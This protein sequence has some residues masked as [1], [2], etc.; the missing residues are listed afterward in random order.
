MEGI[1]CLLNALEAET[2]SPFASGKLRDHNQS[3]QSTS[4]FSERNQ[5]QHENRNQYDNSSEVGNFYYDK[6]LYGKSV[7][8]FRI[9]DEEEWNVKPFEEEE[10]FEYSLL[11]GKRKK[12]GSKNGQKN[13]ERPNNT[14]NRQIPRKRTKTV[15]VQAPREA[16][17]LSII[18]YARLYNIPTQQIQLS[19]SLFPAKMDRRYLE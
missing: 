17:E 19:T 14:Y 2:K 10:E 15:E 9:R 13:T 4:S 3:I 8:A 11:L 7:K 6:I 16:K 1:T 18:D 5:N 12:D